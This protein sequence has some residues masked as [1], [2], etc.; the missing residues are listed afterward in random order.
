MAKDGSPSH[1][2]RPRICPGFPVCSRAETS[3]VGFM[4]CDL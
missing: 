1:V 2:F 4:A 3:Y